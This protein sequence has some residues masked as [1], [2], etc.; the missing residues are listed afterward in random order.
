MRQRRRALVALL[1][2]PLLMVGLL[3][4]SVSARAPR[5]QHF[6]G[7]AP[8]TVTCTLSATVSFSPRLTQSG[9][10][11]DPSTTKGK[12]SGCTTTDTAVTIRGG[13]VSGSYAPSDPPN[14]DNLGSLMTAE[15]LTIRWK[16]AVDGVVGST[17]YR[18]AATFLPSAVSLAGARITSPGGSGFDIV[19][20]PAVAHEAT[21]TGSFAGGLS[22]RCSPTSPPVPSRRCAIRKR[23][24]AAATASES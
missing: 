14:C 4:P 17:A 7:D 11:T 18:G 5:H 3:E 12:V 15:T 2:A 24:E 22:R 13:S 19:S 6:A 8:G 10:G 9:G 23:R 1:A 16:G 21:V 20:S